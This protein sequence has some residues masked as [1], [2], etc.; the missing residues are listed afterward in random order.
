MVMAGLSV[1]AAANPWR[2]GTL[3]DVLAEGAERNLPVLVEVYTD[4]C[5]SCHDLE[6]RV[7]PAP[8]VQAVLQTVVPWRIDA[9]KGAGLEVAERYRII[10]YPT[11]LILEPSGAEIERVFDDGVVNATDAPESFAAAI[12]AAIARKSTIDDL[13]LAVKNKP[14]D[15]THLYR[16]GF[17]L[18]ARGRENREAAVLR[19]RQAIDK[20]TNNAFGVASMS[21]YALGKF[22]YFRGEHD[23]DMA[24]RTL[25]ELI[26]R[27][28]ESQEAPSAH[29]WLAR[30][31]HAAG[32]TG[33]ALGM[34]HRRLAKAPQD[35]A[36]YRLFASFCASNGVALEEALM[37]ARQALARAPRDGDLWETLAKVYT[38][39][40]EETRAHEAWARAKEIA[41]K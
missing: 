8:V 29:D 23:Y 33:E 9:E 41:Q 4:W 14:A 6:A 40:G 11:I 26:D 19:L 1:V 34:L 18:A 7:F 38:K 2:S 17:A 28:P 25:R 16:L 15:P 13:A 24:A 36:R 21:L 35:L 37:V 30:S 39:L 5:P 3:S 12:Q 27:Y 31:L 32:R 20:D 10:G 22:L